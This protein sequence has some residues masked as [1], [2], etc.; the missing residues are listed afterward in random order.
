MNDI[1]N[2]A[3]GLVDATRQVNLRR[4]EYSPA[5][6]PLIVR[7]TEIH[8]QY[9]TVKT[10]AAPRDLMDPDTGEV[11]RASVVHVIEECDDEHL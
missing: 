11:V 2:K 8:T 6:N 7:G 4:L 3:M 9:K 10:R 5:E 1:Q